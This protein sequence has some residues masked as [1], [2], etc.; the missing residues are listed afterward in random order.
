MSY[1]IYNDSECHTQNYQRFWLF[2][3]LPE[4]QFRQSASFARASVLPERG[5]F[6]QSAV[7]FAR[8]P[9]CQS[10]GFARAPVLPVM[11]ERQF[12]SFARVSVC[13]SASFARVSVFP[14][15]P[16]ASFSRAP[17]LPERHF[18]Q[19]ASFASN[20]RAPVLPEW[21]FASFARAPFSL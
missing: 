14:R 1:V 13:Q 11:P 10:A 3:H 19:G 21:Q 4:R 5:Q 6:C 18:C 2:I 12:T 7:S 8:A 9:V 20:A 15:A 17:V 16:V